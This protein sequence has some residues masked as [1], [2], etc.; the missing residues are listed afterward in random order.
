MRLKPSL[1]SISWPSLT[2]LISRPSGE[3]WKALANF[4]SELSSCCWVALSW[5]M[6]RTITTSAGVSASWKAWAE[7]SPVKGWPS[8]RRKGI[9]RLRRLSPC[10][11]LSR[12]GPMPGMP[13]IFSSLAVLP[14]ASAIGTPVCCSNALLASSRQP[15]AL[16]AITRISG[17]CW[18]TEANFCSERRRAC[19]ACLAS[20]ISI[21]RPRMIVCSPLRVRVTMSRIHSTRPSAAYIR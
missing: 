16:R 7:I 19:S 17:H 4:S 18:N 13:Q 12:V 11:R 20:L 6:S 8:R 21:I 14:S 9:S 5:L 10:R 1:I 2:R 3:A 15:S